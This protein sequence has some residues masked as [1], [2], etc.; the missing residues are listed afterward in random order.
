[1]P[2]GISPQRWSQ[3]EARVRK[4]EHGL[5]DMKDSDGLPDLVAAF[6]HHDGD[7]S[8]AAYPPLVVETGVRLR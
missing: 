2:D 7:A 8:P 1:V 5:E 4:I 3:A 6:L